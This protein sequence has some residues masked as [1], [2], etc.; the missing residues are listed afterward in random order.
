MCFFSPGVPSNWSPM[1]LGA[2]EDIV[3]VTSQWKGIRVTVKL[4]IQN[5][6]AKARC[7]SAVAGD[8]H[9]VAKSIHRQLEMVHTTHVL[10]FLAT[11][12]DGV[13]FGPPLSFNTCSST[14]H[15]ENYRKERKKIERTGLGRCVAYNCPFS[16][17]FCSSFNDD[18]TLQETMEHHRKPENVNLSKP[19]PAIFSTPPGRRGTKRHQPHHQGAEGAIAWQE[20]D[21]EHQT[22]WQPHQECAWMFDDVWH[23]TCIL[24]MVRYIIL[25]KKYDLLMSCLIYIYI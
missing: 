7:V 18:D 22:Q 3:K 4:T 13:E 12:G 8:L 23:V 9:C 17:D 20:E 19:V 21:Q 5:R 24:L 1:Q 2:S 25:L 16:N 15:C 6:Q 14:K 11:F 10:R